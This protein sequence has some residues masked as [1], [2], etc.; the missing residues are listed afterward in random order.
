MLTRHSRFLPGWGRFAA[1]MC[2]FGFASLAFGSGVASAAPASRYVAALTGADASNNC[3][4]P[5]HPC[6]T[7]QHAIAEASAG[8]TVQVAPGTYPENLTISKSLTLIGPNAGIDPNQGPRGPEATID[9]GNTG[10]AAVTP[11]AGGVT[12]EGFTVSTST[13]GVGA[14]IRTV[15]D[16]IDRL[17]IA[18]DIIEGGEGA[19]TLQAGGEGIAIEHNSIAGI[20][21]DI[22][23]GDAAYA[24]LTIAGN[25]IADPVTYYGIFNSGAGTI[26][27]LQ[28]SGNAI[29][30][31]SDIGADTS[32]AAVTGNTIDTESPGE[33]GLQIDLHESTVSGNSFEGN[34]TTGCLQLFGSQYGLVPSTEVSVTENSF[35]GCNPYAI[36]LS[37]E[38][39]AIEISGNTISDS[40][41]GIDTRAL[42]NWNVD[43]LGIEIAGN[44]ITGSTHMGVDNTVEGTLDASD[45]WWGCNGG[46]GVSG[47]DTVGTGVEAA[48]YV[49]LTGSASASELGFGAS[50][51]V[52]AAA[53]TDS[54]GAVVGGVPGIV[55]FGSQLGTFSTPA[56]TLAS[57]VGSTFTA[58]FEAGSAG[59]TVGLDGEQ[60]PVPLTIA[61]PPP[62]ISTPTPTPATSTPAPAPAPSEPAVESS[63][64]PVSVQGGQ[65]TLGTISC[66]ESAC[67]IG[68]KAAT[69]KLGGQKFNLKVLVPATMSAGGS[70]KVKVVL[71]RSV[72][73]ALAKAGTGTV[74]VTIA[75]IDANG[76]EITQTIRVKIKQ[77]KK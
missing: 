71:P 1:L 46:P 63:S 56:A 45:N 74:T 21:Y 10:V 68:S 70:A 16:D 58:G 32:A 50:A 43:G 75:V 60:V 51:V 8:D 9:G 19:I 67:Q 14:P 15:G 34:G 26:A 35:E 31:A 41:D 33:A 2:A 20:G 27:G 4:E 25:V 22:Y 39:E 40:Y 48:P 73:K 65:P 30:A 76:V 18:D 12:V 72:R 5:G 61:G 28:M 29:E 69:A 24:D 53:D 13:P 47:C 36:Q 54:N 7:I 37:P 17:T 52:I 11:Q 57:G 55:T 77:Q 62:V 49:V 3:L 64:K 66:G 6:A 42:S 59:I 38:V 44:S 23:L